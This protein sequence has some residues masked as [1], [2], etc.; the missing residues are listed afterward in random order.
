MNSRPVE[1]ITN[2]KKM[3]RVWHHVHPPRWS[4][5]Y[6]ALKCQ[7]A[8]LHP[9]CCRLKL[10]PRPSN[11]LKNS[12]NTQKNAEICIESLRH[13]L[14]I[15]CQDFALKNV[16]KT[17]KN[18]AKTWQIAYDCLSIWVTWRRGLVEWWGLDG[19]DWSSGKHV[20]FKEALR[21]VGVGTKRQRF[22]SFWLCIILVNRK[23][24]SRTD[25]ALTSLNCDFFQF[26]SFKIWNKERLTTTK[27]QNFQKP[28]KK[29]I[30]IS[31]N[32]ELNLTQIHQFSFV[33]LIDT[34]KRLPFSLWVG[35]AAILV[36]LT[37][38]AFAAATCYKFLFA[39]F[40]FACFVISSSST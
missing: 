37:N 26:F 34:E 9:F 11:R 17:S 23:F 22:Q 16:A 14:A 20:T 8:S 30:F 40:V 5:S 15:N 27:F 29:L 4:T 38:F 1:L 39:L 36:L 32:R 10:K 31:A 18:V 12:K 19:A 6:W 13:A 21:L 2:N 33:Y 24:E 3:R 35:V 28:K 7:L 25:V